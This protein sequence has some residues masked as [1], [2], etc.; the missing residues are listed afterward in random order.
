MKLI[1]K[2]TTITMGT[3]FGYIVH[4]AN[5]T[6]YYVYFGDGGSGD[7]HCLILNQ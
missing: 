6:S 7:V 2:L 1:L 3:T 4:T 5:G